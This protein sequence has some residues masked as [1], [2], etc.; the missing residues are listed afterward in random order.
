MKLWRRE[1][2]GRHGT[3]VAQKSLT[4]REAIHFVVFDTP[5]N[6]A[7]SAAREL[8]AKIRANDAAGLPTILITPTGATP[9]PLYDELVRMHEQE[10]LSFRN[11][12]T[13]N[14]DEYYVGPDYKGDWAKH[15]HKVIVRS[16]KDIFFHGW[17]FHATIFIF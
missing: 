17:I 2:C 3:P 10:G 1:R 11:V 15:P 6:Q 16:W 14:M 5:Q 13:F 8:A 4:A 12:H 9:I 7:I